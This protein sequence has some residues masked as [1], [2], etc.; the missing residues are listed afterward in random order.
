M[1]RIHNIVKK[2]KMLESAYNRLPMFLQEQLDGHTVSK[3]E[4]EKM[5][6]EVEEKTGNDF[7][8]KRTYPGGIEEEIVY[9]PKNK[10][11]YP[12]WPVWV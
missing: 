7:Y 5:G 6:F 11:C 8:M 12:L 1:N 2:V 4:L 3:S 9:E 10:R